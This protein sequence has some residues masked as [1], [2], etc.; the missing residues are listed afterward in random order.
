[1]PCTVRYHFTQRFGISAQKAFD[2]CTSFSS[3]D[4]ELMG[5]KNAQRKVMCLAEDT[6][7]LKDTFQIKSGFTTK[8]KLVQTY[9]DQ[10]FWTSTHL[11][12][13]NK[14]SQFLYQISSEGDNSSRLDFTALHL[15]YEKENL[16]KAEVKLLSD[17][18]CKEDSEA[19]KL[20][21]QVMEK[22]FGR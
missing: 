21:A 10:M 1:M 7:I 16:D 15:N 18:L 4:Q 14:Y 19:W 20:L 8:K 2:W 5:E 13:P 6:F 11:T 17:R 3:E 9:P 12:G 22:E